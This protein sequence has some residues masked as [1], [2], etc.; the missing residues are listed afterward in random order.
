MLNQFLFPSYRWK[1]NGLAIVRMIVGSFMIYH[2]FEVFDHVKM[3]NYIKWFTDIKMDY[4]EFVAYS[5]KSLELIAG[6]LLFFGC[7]TRIGAL[8]M[9]FAMLFITFRIGE[10]RVYMEEQHPFLFVVFAFLFFICG[11]GNWSVDKIIS[12]KLQAR[13]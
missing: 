5:G 13:K 11:P 4:K 8:I 1:D 7:L 3:D 2:G 10:G 6:I 9:G 12:R